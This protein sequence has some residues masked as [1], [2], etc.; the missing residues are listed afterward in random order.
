MSVSLKTKHQLQGLK[1]EHFDADG[2]KMR[3]N[4]NYLKMASVQS[5]DVSL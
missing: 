2:R 4:H 1:V 3:L 5:G